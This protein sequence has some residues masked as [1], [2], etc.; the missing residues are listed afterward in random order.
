VKFSISR[1][2]AAKLLLFA[3]FLAALA[4]TP[5]AMWAAA[6]EPVDLDKISEIR[7]EGFRNSQVMQILGELTD[8]IGPRVTGSPNMK[9]ANEW[10]RDKLSEWGLSNPHL[11]GYDF[12]RGWSEEFTS[13]RMISPETTMLFAI[14]KAWAPSTN[15][16]VRGNVIKVTIKSKEDL[17]KLRG[18]LSG[19]IVLLGDA[20]ELKPH[21]EADSIRYND[22]RLEEIAQYG[23]PA[24]RAGMGGP[25]REEMVRAYQLRREV[26]EFF[27]EEKVLAVIEP[28]MYDGGAVTMSGLDYKKNAPAA[29]PVLNMAVEHFGRI[30]RLLERNVPV[31]LEINVRTKFYDDDNNAY[32]TI[33]ELPGMDKKLA[34]EVVIIGGHLDSWHGGTG[35]TDNA[36]GTA[37]AMEAMRILKALDIKPRRTIRIALWSGEEQGL[38]GSKAYVEQHYAFRPEPADPKEKEVPSWMRS[39]KQPPLQFKPDYKK[40]AAYFNLDNGTGKLRGIYAQENAAAVPIFQAW[41][42][43]LKDLGFTTVTMRNT[44]GTDHQSFDGAGIPGFQFIQDPVEYFTR[45]H[46]SNMDTYE[47]VQREDLMQQAV[48][49]AT[50]AYNAA[51]RDQPLPRKALPNDSPNAAASIPANAPVKSAA[52]AK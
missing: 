41:I 21:T 38:L 49:L 50:F 6:S 39:G 19:A 25:N 46:H 11:E 33:A 13:V 28:S 51:M 45:T 35:A 27:A 26:T 52:S 42:E 23:I 31:E 43:P 12:G 40:V 36:T 5:T 22:Q 44:G 37:A 3:F 17:E 16:A 47:R 18:K 34:D 32:N 7:Q 1:Q 20:K 14:P 10:T 30:S 2:H 4:V 9:K 24:G 15:G 29:P 48:I 8:R